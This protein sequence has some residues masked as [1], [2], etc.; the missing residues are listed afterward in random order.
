MQNIARLFVTARYKSI[1]T[2]TTSLFCYWPFAKSLSKYFGL[3][4]VKELQ[5]Q[6]FQLSKTTRGEESF[7]MCGHLFIALNCFDSF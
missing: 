6:L 4:M 3:F 2:N 1:G 7:W 5:L